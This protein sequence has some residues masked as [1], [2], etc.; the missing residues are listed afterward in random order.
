[1]KMNNQEALEA[2]ERILARTFGGSR[3]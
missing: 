1:M 2:A 3:K